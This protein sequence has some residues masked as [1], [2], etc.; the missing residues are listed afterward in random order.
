MSTAGGTPFEGNDLNV[1]ER[2]RGLRLGATISLEPFD[3]TPLLGSENGAR[4]YRLLHESLADLAI[5]EMAIGQ[6]NRIAAFNRGERPV[7]ILEGQTVKG[8]KQ[9]R[10]LVTTVMVAA[11][12]QVELDVGCVE[13]GRWSIRYGAF[14]GPSMSA[15]PTLRAHTVREAKYTGKVD[16]GRLWGDV[17]LFMLKKNVQSPTGDYL[18]L[19]ERQRG[20]VEERARK[21][22]PVPG[23]IGTLV[24]ERG[25]LVALELM[26]HADAWRSVAQRLV[27]SYL[28]EAE[29]QK[30]F[31]VGAGPAAAGP[32]KPE[33]GGQAPGES[34]SLP[35][36]PAASPAEWLDS[37]ARAQVTLHPANGLGVR[38]ALDGHGPRNEILHGSG[39]W[40]QDR[41][42]HLAAFTAEN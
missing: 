31:S 26:G 18:T 12:F 28:L 30:G 34:G 4:D 2:L 27:A 1:S 9:N 38:I 11:Q 39:L 19:L 22:E 8:A 29:M 10:M 33:H 25:R 14:E 5:Q 17:S 32:P 6:V 35:T 41:P 3:V 23:Q 36:E 13:H 24:L 7:L 15:S 20:E 16:Q 21:L 42:V 40:Y 37:L